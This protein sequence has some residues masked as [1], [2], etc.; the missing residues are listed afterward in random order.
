MYEFKKYEI[1]TYML[2]IWNGDCVYNET[3][4]FVAED[5]APLLYVPDKIISVMSYDLK[6][7]Y[8]P[9]VD[10]YLENNMLVRTENSRMPMFTEDEY[11]P[12]NP[13]EGKCFGSTVEGHDYIYFSEGDVFFSHQIHVTYTHSDK[14][15]GFLP[16]KTSKFKNLMNKLSNNEPVKILFYGDSITTG[17]C[18]SKAI[19]SEPYADSW[20]E[21]VVK[22]LEKH[23]NNHK[24]EY[25]NTAV[26][27]FT[28]DMGIANLQS[29]VIDIKPDFM[30]LG[31]G[32]ND[33]WLDPD[34]YKLKIKTMIDALLNERPNCEVA[35]VATMLPHF[36]VAGFYCAQEKQ[37]NALYSLASEYGNV[38]VIP[39]TSM[40]KEILNKKRYYDMTGNNVNHPNDFL[41]RVYAQT[42]IK[43]LLG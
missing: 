16:I 32:M 40:H 30:F 26:G 19:N 13:I 42:V 17:V 33:G 41:A 31:F 9:D 37:E 22:Y 8:V 12:K 25:V 38:D 20:P 11:Y 18:S 3:V 21:M 10:Y 28:S 36:R 27:G 34:G 1:D 39:V 24:I 35:T 7:E 23:F 4:M 2:P 6:T 43:V 29:K 15:N 5:R 14:W